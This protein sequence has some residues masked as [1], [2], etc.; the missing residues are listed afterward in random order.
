MV[1]SPETFLFLFLPLFLAAYYLTPM[2]HRSVTILV[3]S[4]AFYGWWRVDYP[5]L[6]LAITLWTYVFGRRIGAA[7]SPQMA[8]VYLNIGLTRLRRHGHRPWPDDRLSLPAQL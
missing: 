7:C 8:R 6:L 4:Y 1:I 2:R 3:G 5:A